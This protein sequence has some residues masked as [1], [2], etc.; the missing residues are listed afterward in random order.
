MLIQNK[1][2]WG[3]INSGI[4]T[5][6]GGLLKGDHDVGVL[7]LLQ[8]GHQEGVVS[9]DGSHGDARP[10]AAAQTRQPLGRMGT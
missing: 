3:E 5:E 7:L 10:E 9:Y 4:L 2:P 6:P 8:G 1:R